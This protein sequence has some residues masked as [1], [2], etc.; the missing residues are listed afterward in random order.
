MMRSKLIALAALFALTACGGSN[1]SSLSGKE[2]PDGPI[3]VVKIDDTNEA[4]PQIGIDMADV[5]YIEQVEGGLIRL[6]AV[7]STEVPA[8]I[9]PIRSALLVIH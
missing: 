6:A 8:K 9:G 2:G 1:G 5:V 4:H 3:L 7:F